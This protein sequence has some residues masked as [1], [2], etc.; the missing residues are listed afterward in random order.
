MASAWLASTRAVVSAKVVVTGLNFV[1]TFTRCQHMQRESAL[2]NFA[3][4]YF[5]CFVRVARP[6]HR[7]VTLAQTSLVTPIVLY[8]NVTLGTAN[9]TTAIV[10]NRNKL[11]TL[12]RLRLSTRRC[13]ADIPPRFVAKP[14][15]PCIPPGSLGG[16]KPAP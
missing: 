9:Q 6:I 5:Y 15:Q 14:T 12:N 13:P 3:A 16:R 10:L 4:N 7:R 2:L 11:T 8:T 1:V